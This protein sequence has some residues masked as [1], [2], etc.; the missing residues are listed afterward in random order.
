MPANGGSAHILVKVY[1]GSDTS[2]VVNNVMVQFSATSGMGSIQVQNAVT[3]ANGYA[4]AT[5]Y[6]GSL[7]GHL[8]W[9]A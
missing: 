1:S 7:T 6:A 3:D 4:R 9:T 5:A 8:G 2:S